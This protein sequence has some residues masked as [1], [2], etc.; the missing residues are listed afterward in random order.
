MLNQARENGYL[1]DLKR[2]RVE[3]RTTRGFVTA[4]TTELVALSVVDDH[5]NF[6]GTMVL[7]LDD[8]TF[9]RW[10]TEVLEAWTRV[11]AESPS[12]PDSA[13]HLDL[14]SWESV[15][16]SAA[17][18]EPVLTFHRENIDDSVCHLGT[19]VKIEAEC[20]YADEISVEGTIDGQFAIEIKHITKLDFGGGYELALWRMVKSAT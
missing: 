5:C 13:K 12:S 2:E 8:V 6:N 9:L 10:G 15:V 4:V 1:V 3:G 11:L 17:A 14:T 19:N 7:E 20:V 18:E 16:R